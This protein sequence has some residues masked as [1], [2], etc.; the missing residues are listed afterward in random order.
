MRLGG[1][2]TTAGPAT[3]RG[4]CS[5]RGGRRAGVCVLL[6]PAQGAR[7]L[8]RSALLQLKNSG[9]WTI[10]MR[11]R[12]A[13]TV[14]HQC[15]PGVNTAEYLLAPHIG[16]LAVLPLLACTPVLWLRAKLAPCCNMLQASL[17]LGFGQR[18]IRAPPTV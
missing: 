14:P 11:G 5:L 8:R 17:P 15:R 9:T 2:V 6:S 18:L 1:A 3:A 7:L 10:P 16:L 4:M 13:T 12:N